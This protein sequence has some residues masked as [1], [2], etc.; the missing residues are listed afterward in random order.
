M[1][2]RLPERRRAR[3]PLLDFQQDVNRLFEGFFGDFGLER[4][5]LLS[6]RR[7]GQAET[8]L[9]SPEVDIAETDKEVQLVAELPGLDEKD[10]TVEVDE[11]AV[12]I[13]GEKK[14]EIED[15][16]R[17]WQQ[18]ERRYGSFHRVVPL[19][20]E[21]KTDKARACFKKGVLTI[22]LPKADSPR[23]KVRTITIDVD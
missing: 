18:V 4:F 21:V 12:T 6:G 14:E 10:V 15:K 9:F 11:N 13:R 22:A 1:K 8:A 2:N 19:P 20:A 7:W 16:D 23:R 3:H 17:H 5:G